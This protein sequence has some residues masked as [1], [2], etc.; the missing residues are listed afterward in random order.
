MRTAFT[1][2]QIVVE[3][4]M[5]Y[6]GYVIVED[7]IIID[8]VTDKPGDCDAIH[9][10]DGTLA[11]GLIDIHIHGRVGFDVMD[12]THKALSEISRDLCK[13]GVTSWVATT[14]TDEIPNVRAALANV[15]AYIKVQP[16][17][18]ATILGSFLEGPFLNRIYRGAHPEHLLIEPQECFVDEFLAASGSSLKR[19]AIAPELPYANE[20]I[21]R[22]RELGI[23][24]AAAHTN[25]NFSEMT[26]AH[27]LG[28]D[29]GVHLFNGMSPLH[30]REPGCTGAVLYLDML[31]EIIADGIHVNEAI[32]NLAYRMKGYKKLVL[33]SDCMRAGGLSDGKYK[34]GSLDVIVKEGITRTQSGSLAGSTCELAGS[35]K[36]MVNQAN[37]PLW[38]AIQMATSVPAK[39]MDVFEDM[40]SVSVG[41]RANLV[42][43]DENLD[44]VET[45]MNGEI[46]G[47]D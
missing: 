1:A 16:D 12:A 41:K 31:A 15:D 25:A 22:F 5:I 43:F 42:I 45:V 10:Y 9:R 11:P 39:Y 6:G 21:C 17:K 34:L 26:T 30:H 37:V 13:I 33:I 4:G 38:E 14:V 23:K 19:V 44:I 20:A 28:V 40:G 36:M 27:N 24:V 7:G 8:I 3:D 32:L 47:Y 29:C 35:I 2:N 46:I 18:E